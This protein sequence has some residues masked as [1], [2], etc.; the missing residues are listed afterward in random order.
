VPEFG[1]ETSSATEA[2][3]L[4]PP[5]QEIEEPAA[6]PEAPL[7]KLIETKVDEDKAE[8]SKTEE[9]TKM[10]EILSPSAEATVLKAEKVLQ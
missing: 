3:E 10:P 2:K 4:A 5:T 6:M 8:R 9:A 7:T 1:G